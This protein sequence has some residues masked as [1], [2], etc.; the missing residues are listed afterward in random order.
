MVTQSS[1]AIYP[2]TRI[3]A[4]LVVPF[5]VLAFVILYV[6]PQ[7][8]GERFAWDIQPALTAVYMGAGYIGG[9]W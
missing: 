4:A 7:L 2:L 1:D 9:A 5:V 3:V 8:S 6:F